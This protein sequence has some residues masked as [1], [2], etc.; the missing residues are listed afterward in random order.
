MFVQRNNVE[1]KI[2]I[3]VLFAALAVSSTTYFTLEPATLDRLGDEDGWVENLSAIDWLLA[4]IVMFFL[5]FKKKNVWY[6]LLA[7]LFFVCVGEEISWGQRIIGFS[8]PHGIGNIQGEFNLHNIQMWDRRYGDKSFWEVMFTLGRL[9]SIFWLLYCCILP[10]LVKSFSRIELITKKIRLPIV[11][12]YIGVFFLL[13]YGVYK[14][15]EVWH[16][17]VCAYFDIVDNAN[18]FALLAETREW[19]GSLAFLVFAL[20]ELG[21]IVRE[22][23]ERGFRQASQ[24]I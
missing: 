24:S 17:S 14:Y 20:W 23:K 11:P 22:E 12:I 19:Y 13:N 1:M 7:I 8:T 18:C 3:F 4:S 10:V 16:P 2:C 21:R 15:Y 5:F 9:F 6:L